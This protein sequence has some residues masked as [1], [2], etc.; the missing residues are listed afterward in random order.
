MHIDFDH[1]EEVRNP[2]FKGGTGA[3]LLRSYVDDSIRIMLGIL[4][5]GSSIGLHT[6]EGTSETVYILE[7][8]GKVLYD[9]TEIPLHTGSCHYCPEGHSHSLINNTDQPLKFLGIVPNLG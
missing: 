2:E 9:G 7:G 5:P 1:I 6:H 3:V 4:E 8:S